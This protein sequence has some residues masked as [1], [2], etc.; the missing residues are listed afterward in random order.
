[1][2]LLPPPPQHSH[3]AQRSNARGRAR[4]SRASSKPLPR[5]RP[6]PWRTFVSS[7]GRPAGPDSPCS[8]RTRPCCRS[9]DGCL[10]TLGTSSRSALAERPPC[11]PSS[12]SPRRRP[13][14]GDA[15]PSPNTRT[16]RVLR[17]VKRNYSPR[18]G[19]VFSDNV[20]VHR[21]SL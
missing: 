5:S 18:R 4:S 3:P 20:A 16:R 6:S 7:K 19:I 21:S 10:P 13:P 8:G 1:M 9:F 11:R 15:A 12:P 17:G 2:A 14:L